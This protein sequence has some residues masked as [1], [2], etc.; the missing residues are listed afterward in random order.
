MNSINSQ[1][2]KDLVKKSRIVV[3][4][5]CG[6][7]SG[8][9]ERGKR[10]QFLPCCIHK[11]KIRGKL[12]LCRYCGK[13]FE[14]SVRVNVSVSCSD[15]KGIHRSELAAR[16]LEEPKPKQNLERKIDC[17]YYSDCLGIGGRLFESPVACDGCKRYVCIDIEEQLILEAS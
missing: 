11:K 17:K 14:T 6:C 13:V 16:R 3:V 8:E 4:Y 2:T 10:Y 1:E 15:C 7:L 12:F 5:E 9:P